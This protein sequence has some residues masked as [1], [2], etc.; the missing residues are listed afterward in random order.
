MCGTDNPSVSSKAGGLQGRVLWCDAEAN[1][2]A[3]DSG[4][5]VRALAEHCKMANINTVVVDVKPLSG[6][7]LYAS[8]V[9]PRL[10]EWRGRPYPRDDDLLQTMTDEFRRVEIDVYAAVNVFSEGAVGV[11]D[12]TPAFT[13]PEWQCV[14]YERHRGRPHLVPVGKASDETGAVFVNPA[15]PEVRAYELSVIAEI[16]S[17]YDVAGVVLDRMRYP[18]IQSDFSDLSRASFEAWLGAKADHF[19][20]DIVTVSS[21]HKVVR[22]KHF[23]PW[24]EWRASLL[25]DFVA[26]VRQ[27]VRSIRS[28]AKVAAYVGSWYRS[29]FDV[30]ANWGSPR[31]DPGYDFAGPTYRRTGFADLL[32]W[33]CT[34][35]YYPHPTMADARA[36][37]VDE[38]LSVEAACKESI[39]A[40]DQDTYVYG[41]L[42]LLQYARHSSAFER[43]VSV[44]TDITDGV[45][46]FDLVYVRDYGWWNLLERAFSSPVRAP[47][48]SGECA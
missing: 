23:G 47:H 10:S 11:S 7:V 13:H 36:A 38:A 22:G 3:L 9:A 25:H 46:L 18:D 32:D 26:D 41:G 16:V 12:K 8:E 42:Y 5:K 2:W 30:G 48:A 24:M 15:H 34:G 39:R 31:R 1:L 45:M 28:N 35:C 33:L 40:V 44:C 29:C 4:E 6:L 14:R 27:T 43:A 21:G 19:P 17:K 20:E 37:E